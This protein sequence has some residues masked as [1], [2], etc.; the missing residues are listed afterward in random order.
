VT[1]GS[2][3]PAAAL[4]SSTGTGDGSR[5]VFEGPVTLFGER[6]VLRQTMLR[7]SPDSFGILNEQRIP[8]GSFRKVDAYAYTRVSR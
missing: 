8:D 3:P 4:T 1:F 2:E 5:L 6:F 7:D